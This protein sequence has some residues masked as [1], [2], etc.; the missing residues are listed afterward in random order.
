MEDWLAGELVEGA[1]GTFVFGAGIEAIT[2]KVAAIGQ[3]RVVVNGNNATARGRDSTQRHVIRE[4]AIVY[5]RAS[6]RRREGE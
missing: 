3:G 4:D 5:F 2:G 6:T 1:E